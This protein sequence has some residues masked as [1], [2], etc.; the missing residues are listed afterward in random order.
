[1]RLAAVI[2]LFHPDVE[3]LLT[4]IARFID[5]IDIL[6]IYRNSKE[7][8]VYPEEYIPKIK[9][10]G[11]GDNRYVA[12]ALN[13]CLDYCVEEGYEYLLTMDQDSCW[14]GFKLFKK[15]VEILKEHDTVIYA[16]NVNGIYPTLNGKIEVES[17]ITSGSLCKVVLMKRLG[18][19]REDYKIYWVDSEFCHWAHL[20]GYKIKVFTHYNLD[21]N[22]G[23]GKKTI[24]GFICANY[25]PAVYY[26][27]FRNM[28]W[29]RRE[30]G[31]VPSLKCIC[32]TSL[33]Y[34]RGILLGEK[35][36]RE[37]LL[38]ILKGLFNGFFDKFNRRIK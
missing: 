16:P 29:M 1:M 6:I 35:R 14:N 32:Y 26:F 18:G 37:K 13:E 24:G 27:M 38:M 33:F 19:F 22:F 4:N 12:K 11:I 10:M 30:Y 31:S 9:E 23:N 28:I 8:V 7:S 21:Q 3:L 36:K 34:I 2:I 17:V 25:S 20:N 15:E 5:D